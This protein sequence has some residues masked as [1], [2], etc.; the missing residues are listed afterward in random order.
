MDRSFDRAGWERRVRLA[1]A[2]EAA[3]QD[4]AVM[5]SHHGQAP[6]VTRRIGGAYRVVLVYGRA[7]FSELHA[8]AALTRAAAAIETLV[9]RRPR[10]PPGD[11]T[12]GDVIAFRKKPR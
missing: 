12:G 8:E 3:R 10:L 1:Q 5:A 4:H 11:V 2:A 6:F 7:T 9:E